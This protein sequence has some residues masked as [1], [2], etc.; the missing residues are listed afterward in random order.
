[1]TDEAAPYSA[2]DALAFGLAD[3]LCE[4]HGLELFL[5]GPAAGRWHAEFDRPGC[6]GRLTEGYPYVSA[7]SRAEAIRQAAEHV[8]EVL[9]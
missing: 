9:A 1:M 5:H 4:E 8:L 2:D 7:T 3:R 6:P